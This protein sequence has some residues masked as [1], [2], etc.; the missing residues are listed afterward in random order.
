MNGQNV[1]QL[2]VVQDG[3]LVGVLTRDAIL[4]SLE[5]RRTLGLN[6]KKAP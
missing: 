4:R 1:N 5:V 6:P 3:K 2:P